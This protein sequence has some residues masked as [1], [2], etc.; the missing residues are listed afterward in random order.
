MVEVEEVDRPLS[1]AAPAASTSSGDGSD[2]GLAPPSRERVRRSR[3]RRDVAETVAVGAEEITFRR[4]GAQALARHAAPADRKLLRRRVAMMELEDRERSVVAAALAPTAAGGN[5]LHL[6]RLTLPLLIAVGERVVASPLA[7]GP[8][9]RGSGGRGKRRR[10]VGAEGRTVQTEPPP[11]E[12]PDLPLDD[13][14][15]REGSRAGGADALLDGPRHRCTRALQRSMGTARQAALPTT[16]VQAHRS[17]DHRAERRSALTAAQRSSHVRTLVLPRLSGQEDRDACL[18][19]A[20]SGGRIRTSSQR[21]NS[22]LHDRR[23]AP[24]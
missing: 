2:L 24:E 20:S 12:R 21:I 8:L 4:L 19:A 10:V 14:F 23:A 1:V 22:P 16:K 15:R 18:R 6:H 13:G 3:P 5:E 9:S 11:V 7:L 17:S